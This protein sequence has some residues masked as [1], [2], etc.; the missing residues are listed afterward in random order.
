MKLTM[1]YTTLMINFESYNF[2]RAT[3]PH[4]DIMPKELQQRYQLLAHNASTEYVNPH[5]NYPAS[6]IWP[7][8]RK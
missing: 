4:N 1:Q 6:N 7:Q 3:G 2:W 5:G 8:K